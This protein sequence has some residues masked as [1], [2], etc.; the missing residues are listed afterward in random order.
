MRCLAATL[1]VLLAL[2]A[3]ADT[4]SPFAQNVMRHVLLHEM[5]HALIHD[6]DLPML[7]NEEVM[8]D[9]FAHVVVTQTYR[10]D[11]VAI[12]KDRA[13]SWLV[14]DSA[15]SPSE[16]D[17][18]GEHELDARR[19]YRAICFL[20][21]ADPAEFSSVLRWIGIS[22]HDGNACS[23]SAPDAIESWQRVL[24][25]HLGDGARVEVIY[26]DAA[27]TDAVRAS[28]VVEEIAREMQK[29][30]WSQ[31]VTLHYDSCGREAASWSRFERRILFCDE[32]LQRFVDQEARAIPR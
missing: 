11:A 18:K 32:Y 12:L 27:L 23:E 6:F 9:T 22:D 4:L 21:G 3:R 14:E 28:G 24:E 5:A 20:Y 17:L 8:A 19:A 15:V 13:R 16:Y 30:A 26:G 2:P 25:P 29:F 1:L 31:D 7:G 10:D